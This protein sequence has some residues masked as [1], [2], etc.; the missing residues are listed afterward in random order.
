MPEELRWTTA[1]DSKWNYSDSLLEST[2]MIPDLFLAKIAG[3]SG[4][5][6][7]SLVAERKTTEISRVL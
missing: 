7:I 5:G 1:G 3:L 2:V 6:H 4:S